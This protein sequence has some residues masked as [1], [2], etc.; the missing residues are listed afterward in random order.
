M[1]GLSS[2]ITADRNVP[3]LL[4][5]RRSCSSERTFVITTFMKGLQLSKHKLA[6]LKL[7][8]QIAA[9][10]EFPVDGRSFCHQP[11]EVS[12]GIPKKMR[13]HEG[14]AMKT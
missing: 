8:N 3:S 6:V 12:I 5:I 2:S 14:N 9:K 4:G 1:F 10:L 7:Q 13:S 11:G